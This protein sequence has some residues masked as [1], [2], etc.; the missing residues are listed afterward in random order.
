MK[1]RFM[2]VGVI[3]TLGLGTF[4]ASCKKDEDSGTKGCSCTDYWEDGDKETYTV[5][6]EEME[7]Y[8]V[9]DCKGV[10][11]I[12]TAMSDGEYYTTCKSL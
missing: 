7:R 1:K 11:N 6:V 4:L 8:S 10:A 9:S 2:L 12:E 5:T 3:T